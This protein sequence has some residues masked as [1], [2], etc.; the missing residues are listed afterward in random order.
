MNPNR[1][2]CLFFI[3]SITILSFG[4]QR[5]FFEHYGPD[6]GLPQHTIMSILQDKRGFMWFSTWN[7]LC[8]FDGYNFYTYRIQQGD[9]YHMRSNR[10]DLITEDKYGFIWTLPYDREPHRFDPRTEEFMGIRSLKGHE[11][12]TF[13]S[14]KIITTASGKVWLLSDNMGCVC[15][16]DSAFNIELYNIENKKINGN[17]VNNIYE[18]QNGNSWILT[19]N[20]LYSV[21]VDGKKFNSYFTEKAYIESSPVQDFYS[22]LEL[23]DKIW[24][25][26]GNGRIWIYDKQSGQTDLL[27]TESKS[28]IRFIGN[29]DNNQIVI[30]T[31]EDGFFIYNRREKVLNKYNKKNLSA[32]HSD[33]ILSTYLDKSKNIWFEVDYPGIAKFNPETEELKHFTMKTESSVSN[34]FPSNFFIFE[35]NANRL[36]VHPRGGGFGW[37]NPENDVLMPF[38]NEPSSP[39]WRFSNVM[40]T[41]FSDKQGNLWLSTRSHGLDKVIFNNDVFK[42]IVVDPNIHSTINNDIRSVFEDSKGNLWVSTK[43]GKVFI[44]DQNLAQKGYLCSNGKIEY[45]TPI[46]G[47]TYCITEDSKGNIWLGTKGEG[48]YKLI[49]SG[50]SYRTEHYRNSP[51]NVYSLSSNSVYAILEDSKNR[52][53]VGTYGGGLN[54]LDEK[55]NRFF[56]DRNNLKNYPTQFG[57]QIRTMQSDKYGNICIGTT[58][59]LIIFSSEFTD[60]GQIDYKFYT[61][62]PGDN[63]SLSENDVY[64]ICTTKSGDTYLATFGGGINKIETVDNNG[65]PTKFSSY[66][67]RDGLPSDVILMLTEDNKGKLWIASE[68]NLTKFDPEKKS[69]ETYSEINR[70]IEGQNFSEGS[71]LTSKTGIV[72]FGYSKGVL[73]I[74][75]ENINRNIFKPYVAL[76]KLQIANKD[77][78]IGGDSPLERNIND[79]DHIKLNHKQ[80]FINIEFVALDFVE[81]KRILYAYK[82]DGFDD[83]W[84]ITKEQRIAN[85]NNLLPGK[86]TFRVKSTNSDGIWMDNEHTLGIEITPS[87]WQTGWAYLLYVVLI[88]GILYAI[89]RTLFVFYRL[90][91]KVKLEHEQTEM[92]TRFFTDISHEI[93]TPLTMIVSPVENIIEN[94]ST[95]TDIKS[96][97]QLV[98]KNTNRMQRM[99]NQ[100]LDFRKIQKQKLNIQETAIGEYVADICNN[101]SKT[102]E[103]QNIN[104][105]FHDNS[106]GEKIWVDRDNVEKLVFNLLSNAFKYTSVEKTIEVFVTSNPKDKN[107]AIQVKDEG[108]GMSKDVLNKLFTRFASFNKDKSKPSTGIGLS[109]VKEVADKHHAKL[110]V[111]SEVNEGSSFT[112]LFPTGID[113]FKN[114]ENAAFT[115]A[116]TEKD[117]EPIKVQ[118]DT[119]LQDENLAV[120]PV[121]SDKEKHN[122][123][124]TILVVEDDTDLR[125]FISTIL[126]PHYNVL[127]AENGQVGYE[128]ATKNIPDFIVSDIMMPE[129][130]GVELLQKIRS[131]TETSHIPF[132]LLTAKTDMDSKLHGLDYGADD[133][134]TKPFSVK[135]LKARIDNIIR[136]R[137]RL[138]E[139]YSTGKQVEDKP[140][141]ETETVKEAETE[142][143]F[144]PQDEAFITKIKEEVEKNIDNSDF[145]VEDLAASVAMSRTVFFKKLKSLTGFAPIEFIRDIKIKH[146]AALIATQQYTIKEVSYMIGI[147][148][149][150]YFT[151]LF[152]NVYGM[153]P[154]EYK[155]LQNST[156]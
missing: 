86:Y 129:V 37:Y 130:D 59:G 56:N 98:L 108:R 26:A 5:C 71:R 16:T 96:Q 103:Y 18:D 30:S 15:V 55:T 67:T 70:L 36:W 58:L 10:I 73:S 143:K 57:S 54:L 156:K 116:D 152:K 154:T 85:Y 22:V 128:V 81:P 9:K 41:A 39:D 1:I 135:Y 34:V 43:G 148:D 151:Q 77:V 75:P 145:V 100:I 38:F 124:E 31:R 6:D 127:D 146:A 27:Q 51:N 61:R 104:L 64:D 49:P 32:M 140:I 60:A 113:H 29:I 107:I 134:I 40:H 21:S 17:K 45:G 136:Q 87:F 79:V 72:Y 62:T 83:D 23:D 63:E 92:K 123:K 150:K 14:T 50:N 112:V 8:R 12:L 149:T 20:G 105:K 137:K 66:T 99:V 117:T 13:I 35:D 141:V 46:E 28:E 76:S 7:G 110:Q 11:D 78:P 126:E 122:P 19:N 101:F 53:W 138:Y 118:E 111:E 47:I 119:I 25:G 93:R 131:N 84:I 144:T 2:F 4:Q 102:A 109:I 42:S 142:L 106:D 68:G 44:Y 97:L 65:F 52:I 121:E 155:N 89:L 82:L 125:R 114:D 33:R 91:D 3:F 48:V 147:S 88:A 133:Y 94:D 120:E 132:I 69:F 90:R 74:D 95:P 80:N 139:S 24:F 115:Y 153:T